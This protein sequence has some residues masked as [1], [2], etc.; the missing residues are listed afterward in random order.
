MGVQLP[1]PEALHT[2]FPSEYA[3]MSKARKLIRKDQVF[4]NGTTNG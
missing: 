2:L 3:S 1:L 4:V